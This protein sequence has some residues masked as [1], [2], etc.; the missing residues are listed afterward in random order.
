MP[1]SGQSSSSQG[2]TIRRRKI[3]P[4]WQNTEFKQMPIIKMQTSN[5]IVRA[6]RIG[7]LNLFEICILN[8]V[9]YELAA[10]GC[11]LTRSDGV[12]FA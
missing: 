7:F 1:T 12:P 9:I 4:K 8:F 6:L 5:W 11:A 3:N 2:T 10:C